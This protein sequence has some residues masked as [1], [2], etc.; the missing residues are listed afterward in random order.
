[1]IVAGAVLMITMGAHQS[2]GLFVAPL[3]RHTGLGIAKISFAFA[4][5]Q[6]AWGA[7]QSVFG[8][9]ADRWGPDGWSR[10]VRSC[11]PPDAS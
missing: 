1:M 3:N 10:W 6:F 11:W 8:A 4:V 7:V 5:G 9:V 2:L